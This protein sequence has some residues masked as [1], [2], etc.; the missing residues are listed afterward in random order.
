MSIIENLKW[1]YATKK[2]DTSKKVTVQELSNLQEAIQ[3]AASS[4]G[5]EPYKIFIIENPALREKL[6]AA[7]Y[8]QAQIVDASHLL[9][10]TTMTKTDADD[11]DALMDLTA[12]TRGMEVENLKGYADYIKGAIGWM[13]PEQQTV[14]NSRQTYIALGTALA[15]CAEMKIDSCPMEGFEAPKFDEILGLKEKGLTASCLLTIGYRSAEDDTA[16]YKKVR[17]PLAQLFETL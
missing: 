17:K 10:F 1:R 15:A 7:A 11:V 5:F 16:K 6:Q 13:S 12:K 2:F 8:N 3:L 4:Y 9:V 14:W